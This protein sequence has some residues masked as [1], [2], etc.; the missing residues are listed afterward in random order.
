VNFSVS[1]LVL[2]PGGLQIPAT[3]LRLYREQYITIK[4]HGPTYNGPANLPI[5]TIDT[6]PDPLVP[7]IDPA[8]GSP[9]VGGNIIAVP[10]NL[11]AGENMVIWVD[12]FVPYGTTAGQ[13]AGSYTVTSDQG[14][15]QGPIQVNVW[16][17]TLPL[18]SSLKST[19]TPCCGTIPRQRRTPSE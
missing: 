5:T 16:D 11:G 1:N 4:K 12:V 10:F 13:Y 15:V 8:T 17:F 19:F 3:N 18:K 9:P 7:F 6:F 2:T 14:S